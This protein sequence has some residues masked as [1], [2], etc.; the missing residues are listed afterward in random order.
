MFIV[1]EIV[2]KCLM[3]E[4]SMVSV[5]QSLQAVLTCLYTCLSCQPVFHFL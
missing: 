1:R 4:L 5:S 2:S 3:C